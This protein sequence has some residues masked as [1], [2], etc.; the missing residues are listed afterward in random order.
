MLAL[1]GPDAG[2]IFFERVELHHPVEDYGME[3]STRGVTGLL[4]G[5]ARLKPC[6]SPNDV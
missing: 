5:A 4:R 2:L 6:P 3:S 1:D